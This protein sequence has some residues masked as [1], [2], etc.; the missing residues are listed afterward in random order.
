MSFTGFCFKFR[1]FVLPITRASRLGVPV[2]K[3]CGDKFIDWNSMRQGKVYHLWGTYCPTL[4]WCVCRFCLPWCHHWI[5][6]LLTTLRSTTPLPVWPDYIIPLFTRCLL[7]TCY[8]VT[9][10]A[11]T[12]CDATFLVTVSYNAAFYDTTPTTLLPRS[13]RMNDVYYIKHITTSTLPPPGSIRT[14]F[15]HTLGSYP[16]ISLQTAHYFSSNACIVAVVLPFCHRSAGRHVFEC[17]LK[18]I[19]GSHQPV[20]RQQV[21]LVVVE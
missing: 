8:D 9:S 11:T 4:T 18:L 15:P 17:A 12:S 16:D 6:A 20:H 7:A 5:H 14:P 1:H 2:M 10:H 21:L 19:F 13:V 3:W